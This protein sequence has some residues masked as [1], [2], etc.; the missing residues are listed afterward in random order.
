MPL[1]FVI[2]SR[3]YWTDWGMNTK[4]EKSNLDGTDRIVLV[5]TLIGWP[6]GLAIDR[7]QRKLYWADAKLD[8]IEYIN[9]DGSGRKVLVSENIPH[10]FGF[11]LLGL[12]AD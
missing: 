4:I 7:I 12:F 6:N 5:N 8:R 10:V 11:S 1:L 9:L 2:F 3:M